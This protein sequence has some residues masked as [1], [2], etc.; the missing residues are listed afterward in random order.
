MT[1]FEFSAIIGMH[2]KACEIERATYNKNPSCRIF[3]QFKERFMLVARINKCHVRTA[4]VTWF[5]LDEV[6]FMLDPQ[7]K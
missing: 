6:T 2:F 7:S 5:I 3:P 4:G 1:L